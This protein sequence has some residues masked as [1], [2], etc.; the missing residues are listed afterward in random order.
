MPLQDADYTHDYAIAPVPFVKRD[1]D[2]LCVSRLQD[3]KNIPI[4]AAALKIYRQKYSPIRMTLILGKELGL[5]LQELTEGERR[6]W[7]EVESKLPEC[8]SL[9][10][11]TNLWLDLAVQANYELS[12]NE[13]IYDKNHLLSHV[14]GLDGIRR[15]VNFYMGRFGL[16]G[17][18]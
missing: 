11:D 14:R 13:F 1:I 17:T 9:K 5:N 18:V 12:L 15:L 4:I 3:L 10:H 16:T 8:V 6:Q 7:R 2:V